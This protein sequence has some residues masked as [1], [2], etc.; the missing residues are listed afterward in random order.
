M[1]DARDAPLVGAKR[2]TYR[3]AFGPSAGV[4]SLHASVRC[5][6]D[7]RKSLGQL[8]RYIT[9]SALA[10]ECVQ[11]NAGGQVVL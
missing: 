10:N 3:I 6:A 7:E 5:A 9:R 1:F 2:S 4:S 8:C 11:W